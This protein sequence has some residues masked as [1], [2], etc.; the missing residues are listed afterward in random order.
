METNK[1]PTK[2]PVKKVF[3]VGPWDHAP[4]KR[5][6]VVGPKIVPG[7]VAFG[8]GQTPSAPYGFTPTAAQAKKGSK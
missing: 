8:V 5:T 3:A 7:T 4:K 2:K 1:K 6:F